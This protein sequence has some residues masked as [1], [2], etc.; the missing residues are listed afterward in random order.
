[1]LRGSRAVLCFGGGFRRLCGAVL[2]LP[3]LPPTVLPLSVTF[4]W[5]VQSVS[6]SKIFPLFAPAQHFVRPPGPRL[7][8]RHPLVFPFA[9]RCKAA[10][11]CPKNAAITPLDTDTPS[12]SCTWQDANKLL[13]EGWKENTRMSSSLKAQ[14]CSFEL[15]WTRSVHHAPFCSCCASGSPVARQ[16][17]DMRLHDQTET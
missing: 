7:V 6:S 17:T 5:W 13:P 11:P 12:Q 10:A 4:C 9:I 3:C 2:A 14:G 15:K 1:M 16:Q 8:P